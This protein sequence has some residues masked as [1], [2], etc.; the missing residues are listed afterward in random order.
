MIF[1]P[2]FV[3]EVYIVCTRPKTVRAVKY[4]FI[5]T[6]LITHSY[7]GFKDNKYYKNKNINDNVNGNS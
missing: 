2:N 4:S 3:S 6:I 1:I 5:A 7:D